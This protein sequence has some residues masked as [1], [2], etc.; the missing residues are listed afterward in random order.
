MNLKYF[1]AKN[2]NFDLIFPPLSQTSPKSSNDAENLKTQKP[3][4]QDP[5]ESEPIYLFFPNF[6]FF[7]PQPK[8]T[9][10]NQLIVL[11]RSRS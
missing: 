9:P 5:N 2:A 6:F 11:W 4:V 3:D 7:F 1:D 8:Q 10:L